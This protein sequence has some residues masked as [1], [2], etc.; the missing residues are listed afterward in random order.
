MEREC[1]SHLELP[2]KEHMVSL[3]YLGEYW[4]V[5]EKYWDDDFE[6]PY[7]RWSLYL[8]HMPENDLNAQLRCH[9]GAAVWDRFQGYWDG[10]GID[11]WMQFLT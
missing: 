5:L 10:V 1:G 11:C 7:W 4:R 8:F 2:G 6:L 3:E 9:S